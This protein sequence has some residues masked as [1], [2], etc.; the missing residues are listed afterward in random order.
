MPFESALLMIL[1]YICLRTGILETASFLVK[2]QWVGS[3]F[4][5]NSYMIGDERWIRLR[6]FVSDINVV[7]F[8]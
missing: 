5:V 4:N 2:F 7:L 6:H 8:L 1:F 3:S